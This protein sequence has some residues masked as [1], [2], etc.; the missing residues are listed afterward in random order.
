MQ[1][2]LEMTSND[3]ACATRWGL[4]HELVTG[5]G[6]RLHGVR[7][8]SSR[9]LD[10]GGWRIVPARGNLRQSQA[11]PAPPTRHPGTAHFCDQSGTGVADDPAR[12]SQRTAL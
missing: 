9:S 12:P 4:S 10:A 6:L 3:L 7:Q 11:A 1:T 5:L 8:S 2:T